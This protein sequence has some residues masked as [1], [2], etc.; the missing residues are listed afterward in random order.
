MQKHP[1]LSVKEA[2][3]KLRL[4]ERSVRERLANGSLKGEKRK[5]GLRDKWFVY[6]GSVEAS[7]AKQGPFEGDP[8]AFTD[9]VLDTD[10]VEDVVDAFES[11]QTDDDEDGA[12][13]DRWLDRNRDKV[14]AIAA[15]LLKPL[16]D[17]IEAQAEVIFEQRRTISDQE[18][19]IRLLPDLQKQAEE[20]AKQ[21]ELEHVEKEA[22]K[23]QAAAQFELD[24]ADKDALKQEINRLNEEKKR[25]Q[26]EIALSKQSFWH[27]L[28]GVKTDG[29][30]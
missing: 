15:E 25:L 26:S 12:S 16:A 4:D 21:L 7:L 9:V 2:A 22:L 24:Q 18:R 1:L 11:T 3:E 8:I 13:D 10:A 29:N 23:K 14:Q 5:I 30:A 6:S 28:F 20:R 19:Q 27:K 17:K